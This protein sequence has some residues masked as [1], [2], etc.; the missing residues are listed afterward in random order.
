VEPKVPGR[1]PA[2]PP[3][4]L[5][6]QPVVGVAQKDQVLQV[7]GSAVGPVDQVVGVEPPPALAP[8]EP[9]GPL[10]PVGEDPEEG[11]PDGPA[12]PPDP[13][14]VAPGLQN[15]LDGPVAGQAADRL[16]RKPSSSL[17]L[18]QPRRFC[19][20]LPEEGLGP[21]VDHHRGRVRLSGGQIHEGIG[22]PG[23]RRI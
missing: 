8:G 15:P 9:A 18:R 20:L 23:R 14:R 17:G 12:P 1:M 10:V 2:D 6:D 19:L 16:R 11:A 7:G 22:H 21:G 3:P 13:H 4:A 5:V